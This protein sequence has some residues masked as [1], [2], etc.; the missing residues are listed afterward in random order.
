MM[1]DF[2]APDRKRLIGLPMLPVNHGVEPSIAEAERTLK[3]GAKGLN[4]PVYPDVPYIDERYEP[5]W[6]FVAQAG[7]PLCMHRVSGGKDPTGPGF[8]YKTPGVALATSVTRFFAGVDPLAKLIFTGVF[9]RHPALKI[10]H[11]EINFGWVPFWK[12]TM[13]EVYDR[14]KNW[15]HLP[16]D[17]PPSDALGRNVFV[18]VLDDRL[19]F[20]LVEREPYLADV[21]MFST[22]YP[23]SFCLWP[24]TQGYIDKVTEGVDAA[25]K[26]KILAGN[27][28]R[29]FGLN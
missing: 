28:A 17:G 4:I 7:V 8:A 20:E 29:T 18:T 2:C 10:V 11:A 19:G 6:A 14:Q 3:M 21:A 25:A 22:D 23:H 26:H 9:Q 12:N 16:F 27:A 1:R 15:A 13:D 5:F 24:D